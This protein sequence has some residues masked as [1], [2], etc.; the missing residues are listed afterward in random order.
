MMIET[1]TPTSNFSNFSN[2]RQTL[3]ELIAPEFVERRDELERLANVDEL[4]GLANR[5]A[6]D[7]AE[8]QA[9][10]SGEIFIIFDANNFGKVNKLCGH[11]AGDEILKNYAGVIGTVAKNFKARAFRLGGDE[12]V[13]V[14]LPA[15]AAR[16]RDRV[17]R[18]AAAVD[19]GDFTVSISGETGATLAAADASLQARKTARKAA[20]QTAGECR[21]GDE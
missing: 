18:L 3:A 17:E 2:F 1:P 10:R 20:R 9:R 14:C 7:R 5:R 19:F 8:R 13:V 16:V 15:F 4:T 21:S 6:F 11:A 12:F